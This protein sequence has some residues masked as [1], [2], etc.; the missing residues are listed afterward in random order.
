MIK[1]IQRRREEKALSYSEWA[2]AIIGRLLRTPA[3]AMRKQPLSRPAPPTLRSPVPF[4]ILSLRK[5]LVLGCY[6]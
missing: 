2:L 1:K 6:E 4:V 5:P 3:P